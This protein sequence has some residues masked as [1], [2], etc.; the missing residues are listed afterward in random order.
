[1][2][3]MDSIIRFSNVTGHLEQRCEQLIWVVSKLGWGPHW[4]RGTVR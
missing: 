2:S 1:M 3:A 4:D